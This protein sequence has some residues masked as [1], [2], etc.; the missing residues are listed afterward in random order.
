M[1]DL[2]DLKILIRSH[3]PIICI[4]TVEE[5]RAENVV[6][7]VAEELY[8]PLFTWSA[9]HGLKRTGEKQPAYQTRNPIDALNFIEASSLD[10]IYLFKDLHHNL[11]DPLITRKL[12]DLCEGFRTRERSMILTAPSFTFPP[13]LSREIARY[14]L[15]LPGRE[16]LKKLVRE[17]I[18]KITAQEKITVHIEG[19]DGSTLINNL[20][21]LTLTEAERVLYRVILRDGKLD[22]E[23]LP[24]LLSA[25]KEKVEQSG[26]LE[27]YPKEPSLSDVGGMKNLKH[28]LAIRKGAFGEKATQFGLTPPKGILLLG[29]QGCGK[30][31][32]AKAVAREWQLPLLKLDAARLYNKYIGETEKNLQKAIRLA[33][34]MAPTVLWIDEIEKALSGSGTSD[35]DG[36]VSTRILG[37]LLSWLQEKTASV[38]VVATSND[39]TKLP[40][41]LL[42]KGRLDEIF[43]VDLPNT[44]EREAILRVHLE[45]K[46]RDPAD[47]DLPALV[48]AS[49]G[50]SGA[51]I[52]QAIISA[53]Y[54]AFSGRG[55]L[56]TQ[57]IL[58]EIKSTY[59]LSVVMKEKIEALREWAQ[60]R[61]VPAN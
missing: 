60:G 16:E 57:E 55:V 36:G 44:E 54:A 14:D 34:S 59:P 22:A 37:T 42:R 53:L 24:A 50:F 7:R 32:M 49:K 21:G 40:P 10:G 6:A 61:T 47:F 58:K 17:V 4:E 51:E 30:S 1:K 23:D 31:L 35:G 25:K 45:K 46:A 43:F 39:I 8:L 29:V 52:E 13:E 15:A 18:R 19:K 41:E 48:E 11:T 3:Y 33:E 2:Q 27:F 12:R 5:E 26:V 28:W 38:F 20:T 9:T 56:T